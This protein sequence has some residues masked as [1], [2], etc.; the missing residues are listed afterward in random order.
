MQ[1]LYSIITGVHE[2]VVRSHRANNS[3]HTYNTNL[4]PFQCC[5]KRWSFPQ[6]LAHS[7]A[8]PQALARP[9]RPFGVLQ[10]NRW[11]VGANVGV[12]FLPSDCCSFHTPDCK[13][14]PS[15]G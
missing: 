11:R 10:P 13:S 7:W 15:P 12:A 2:P 3:Q 14:A 9:W 1:D 4:I 6:H 8:G 5:F